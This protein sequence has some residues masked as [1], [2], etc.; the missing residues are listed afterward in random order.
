MGVGEMQVSSSKIIIWQEWLNNE[1]KTVSVVSL[2]TISHQ[3]TVSK[4][5]CLL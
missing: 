5:C 2:T 1:T 4:D 3:K